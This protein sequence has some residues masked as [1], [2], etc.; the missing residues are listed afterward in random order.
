MHQYILCYLHRGN[1]QKNRQS[2]IPVSD[3][4]VMEE[5]W[6]KLQISAIEHSNTTYNKA[7]DIGI[8]RELARNLLPEGYTQT[9]IYV[10]GNIRQWL[11]YFLVR[12]SKYGGTGV[13]HEHE[14]MAEAMQ[15]AIEK[16]VPICMSAFND[17]YLI[18]KEGEAEKET[19]T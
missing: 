6:T 10:S 19:K 4:P 3:D 5:E 11:T 1:N 18:K 14:I 8:G 16:E 15:V 13:Q 2:S 12:M 7:I 17:L 9:Y